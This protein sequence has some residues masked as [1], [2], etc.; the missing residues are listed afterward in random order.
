MLVGKTKVDCQRSVSLP[1][2]PCYFQ[3]YKLATWWWTVVS[4]VSLMPDTSPLAPVDDKNSYH[5]LYLILLFSTRLTDQQYNL[6]NSTVNMLQRFQS[7]SVLHSVWNFMSTFAVHIWKPNSE[8]MNYINWFSIPSF[9]SI[10]LQI[11]LILNILI[12]A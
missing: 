8:S 6:L 7:L 11:T 2:L 5:L 12:N 10:L 1:R 3:S 9:I 4:T